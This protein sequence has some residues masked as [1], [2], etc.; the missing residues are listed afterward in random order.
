MSDRRHN[1]EE[2]TPEQVLLLVSALCDAREAHRATAQPGYAT[3][4]RC[5]DAQKR[6]REGADAE[7]LT[8]L[9]NDYIQL[10]AAA[11]DVV[12]RQEERTELSDALLLSRN[13]WDAVQPAA[14]HAQTGGIA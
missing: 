14:G 9:I 6:M 13:L 12:S 10:K 8:A 5:F 7:F 11:E 2:K 4:Q 3:L 1:S